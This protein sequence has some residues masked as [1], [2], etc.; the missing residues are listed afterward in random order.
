MFLVYLISFCGK[1]C[2]ILSETFFMSF[3]DGV[4]HS[5]IFEPIEVLYT[6][7]L[8]LPELTAHKNLS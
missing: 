1:T 3:Q 5:W 7:L 2:G 4:P 8:S 6:E